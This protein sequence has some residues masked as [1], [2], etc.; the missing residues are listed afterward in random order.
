MHLIEYNNYQITPTEEAFL[1]APIR[2]LYNSDKTKNKEKFMQLL[3]VIYFY[4]D[5]R[6]SYN[7]ITNDKDRLKEIIIQE[8]LPS[9]F[10]IDKALQEAIEIYKKHVITSS[11]LLLQDTKEVIENMRKVLKSIDWEGLEEKDKVNAVKT[12]ASITSMIPK[13]VKDLTEAEKAVTKEIEEQ[14]RA[15]GGQSKT[16]MEDGIIV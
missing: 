6:S 11:Y 3:S 10:K 2:K 13:I 5:P 14:G 16:L 9:N 1:I 4:A 7:Y 15:R 12:V 8:G